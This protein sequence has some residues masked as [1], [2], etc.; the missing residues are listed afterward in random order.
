MCSDCVKIFVNRHC[1]PLSYL[2]LTVSALMDDRI[3]QHVLKVSACVSRLGSALSVFLYLFIMAEDNKCKPIDATAIDDDEEEPEKGK[4]EHTSDEGKDE[5]EDNA[6]AKIENDTSGASN[7]LEKIDMRFKNKTFPAVLSIE[8]DEAMSKQA[9][10]ALSWCKKDEAVRIQSFIDARYQEYRQSLPSSITKSEAVIHA[11]WARLFYYHHLQSWKAQQNHIVED[12]EFVVAVPPETLSQE[13]QT[14]AK[15]LLSMLKDHD[16]AAFSL[17]VKKALTGV[18]QYLPAYWKPEDVDNV[19]HG[20]FK[21]TYYDIL[22]QFLSTRNTVIFEPWLSPDKVEVSEREI[23][24]DLC[25]QMSTSD[26][27]VFHAQV[28]EKWNEDLALMPISIVGDHKNE[29][30]ETWTIKNYAKMLTEYLLK[31]NESKTNTDH[32]DFV[33]EPALAI[34]LLPVAERDGATNLIKLVNKDM[35]MRIEEKHKNEWKKQFDLLPKCTLPETILENIRN[36]WLLDHYFAIVADIVNEESEDFKFTPAVDFNDIPD[37]PERG[38]AKRMVNE[39]TREKAKQLENMVKSEREKAF[40]AF[41]FATVEKDVEAIW[42]REHYFGFMAA[43]LKEGRNDD[44][45]N[46][47]RSATYIELPNMFASP[48]RTKQ[49]SYDAMEEE[50]KETLTTRSVA[51]CHLADMGMGITNR[52][53]VYLLHHDED[54]R[55]VDVTDRKSGLSSRVPII[56]CLLADCTGAIMMDCWRQQAEALLPRFKEWAA[57]ANGNLILLEVQKFGAKAEYRRSCKPCRVLTFGERAEIKKIENPSANSFLTTAARIDERL[58]VSDFTQL[59]KIQVP[60]VANVTGVV[61][62]ITNITYT[63][64]DVPMRYFKIQDMNG[65][66]VQCVVH[67]RHVN[68]RALEDRAQVVM[69]LANAQPAN[70]TP[71]MLWLYDNG[72]MVYM[73]SVPS[74]KPTTDAILLG[75]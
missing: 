55:Y 75:A 66:F 7:I 30:K 23:F 32:N 63:R 72:H 15:K 62:S 47:K 71:A 21:E 48:K 35:A 3:M 65:R 26:A 68:N 46:G 60:F 14:R 16:K 51:Q 40:T 44:S 6:M 34:S 70:N 39:M 9:T 74:L 12:H 58:V 2:L 33:F 49:S 27:D 25:S 69:F 22:E 54:L 50:A 11:E 53:E 36:T 67:G 31:R 56:S 38:Q 73:R 8:I 20:W 64:S 52:L 42:L 45:V 41:A 28:D 4:D 29:I 37:G 5:E 57:E 24:E 18:L 43:V 1:C 59:E 17:K 13:E 19:R 10:D 61:S